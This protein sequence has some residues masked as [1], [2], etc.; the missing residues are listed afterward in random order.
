MNVPFTAN[1]RT[2]CWL[3]TPQPMKR[4]F[5]LHCPTSFV[6]AVSHGELTPGQTFK[7]KQAKAVYICIISTRTRKTPSYEVS[8]AEQA[9]WQRCLSSTVTALMAGRCPKRQSTSNKSCHAIGSTLPKR[10]TL[11]AKPCPTGRNTSKENQL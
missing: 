8:V 11:T 9:M 7:A 6:T 2:V 1:G 4:K 10:A 3:S 5:I